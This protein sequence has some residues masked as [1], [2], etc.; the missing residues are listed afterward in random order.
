MLLQWREHGGCF[1]VCECF[2]GAM[3]ANSI[4]KHDSASDSVC[5]Q[6]LAEQTLLGSQDVLKAPAYAYAV[7]T[8]PTSYSVHWV[9]SD[10]YKGETVSIYSVRLSFLVQIKCQS[11]TR[12]RIMAYR[13]QQ[14][15]LSLW[16]VLYP[17]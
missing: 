6:A 8:S 9:A 3:L 11:G 15:I 10:D 17:P 13:R 12:G 7:K 2:E 4:E 14:I 16:V 1:G 5:V